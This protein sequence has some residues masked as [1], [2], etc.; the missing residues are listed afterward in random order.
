MTDLLDSCTDLPL[1]ERAAGDVVIAQGDAAGPIYLLVEGQLDIS[2]DDV[3]FA[4]IDTPGAIVGEMSALL[5]RPASATVRCHTPCR[6]RV[7]PDGARFLSDRP[8]VALLVAAGLA[9][10]LDNLSR[11]LAD[12]KRQ[13]ADQA[14]H[15]GM[16]DEVLASL[17]H[18]QPPTVQPGSARLPDP[19]Y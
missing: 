10:R 13:L 2:R 7:A 18:H 5:G 9:I 15:L 1:I 12:V 3:D 4:R 16:V 6:L 17:V 8:D 11:Y 14:G 19:E